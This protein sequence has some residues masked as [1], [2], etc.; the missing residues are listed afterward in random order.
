MNFAI[1]GLKL[2]MIMSQHRRIHGHPHSNQ[3]QWGNSSHQQFV[4]G[5]QLEL[6][7]TSRGSGIIFLGTR[8]EKCQSL[9]SFVWSFL[10][11]V[12]IHSANEQLVNH[13]TFQEFNCWLGCK[14][15]MGF[16]EGVSDQEEWW[17]TKAV[18]FKEGDPFRHDKCLFPSN[19]RFQKLHQQSAVYFWGQIFWRMSNY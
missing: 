5:I 12:I 16:F 18:T 2:T 13:M 3:Q 9:T 11:D 14:F 19:H 6:W 15:A 17:S 10:I 1:L 4:L 8:E 7:M